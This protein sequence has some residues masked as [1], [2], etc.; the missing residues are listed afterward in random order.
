MLLLVEVKLWFDL[1]SA[2]EV[3]RHCLVLKSLLSG[4]ETL[5][6]HLWAVLILEAGHAGRA[7]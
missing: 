4:V 2:L 1:S 6:R 7:H 5:Y 3:A